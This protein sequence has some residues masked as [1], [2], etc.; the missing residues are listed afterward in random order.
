L[1]DAEHIVGKV[2]EWHQKKYTDQDMANTN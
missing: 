1:F 2:V